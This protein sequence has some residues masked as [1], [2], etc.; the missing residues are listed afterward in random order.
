MKNRYTQTKGNHSYAGITELVNFEIGLRNYNNHTAKLIYKSINFGKLIDHGSKVIDFGAGVGT[1]AEILKNKYQLI[2][3]CIEI[4][5]VLITVLD[6]KK[7]KTFSNIEKINSKYKYIY[8]SNVLEHIEDDLGA[9]KKL[10]NILEPQGKMII[11]VPANPILF[12]D[13]DYRVG[14]FR[15]YQRKELV[16]IAKDA[17]FSIE[18]C[19]YSDS[20]GIWAALLFKAKIKIFKNSN[21]SQKNLEFYDHFIYPISKILDLIGFKFLFGKNLLLVAKKSGN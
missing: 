9:L 18:K 3:E 7:F 14:H 10:N 19:I 11:Y 16:K 17:G 1:I 6:K 20:L 15:R 8:T 4:D 21:V 5:P 2:I 13:F 12:S